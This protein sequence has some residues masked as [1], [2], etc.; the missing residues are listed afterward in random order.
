M[1][2][3]TQSAGDS[4][5]EI[6]LTNDCEILDLTTGGRSQDC[7]EL[8]LTSEERLDGRGATH[9]GSVTQLRA[10]PA[11]DLATELAVETVLTVDDIA[12]ILDRVG[13]RKDSR[14]Y[15]VATRM[16]DVTLS[17]VALILALPVIAIVAL[18]I[19]VDSPGPVLFKQARVGRNG[20]VFSF[21]K[22]R[23]MYTDAKE[24]FPDYYAYDYSQDELPTL[25]F[26][27]ADDP[28][29][30]RIGRR[31]RR[32]SLDE[33]PNLLNVLKGDMSL[34]GPRPE[35]PQMIRHY[36]PEELKKFSVKPGLTGLAQI[37]GRNILRFKQTI[38]LDL[39]YVDNR[40]VAFD[41]TVLRRTP[42]TVVKMIG[43]L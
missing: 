23:T 4:R 7:A 9:G 36:R 5:I 1:T 27:L 31:L 33:L 24:R 6:D 42:G 22:F 8:D 25:F 13:R 18:V 43:A 38:A 32:T 10:R 20:K 19:A 17:L 11:V 2:R 26:K 12:S 16:I 28:R 34:V 3:A 29:L 15:R 21:Y 39:E 30:T 41:L 35:I 37:S 14:T 40:S